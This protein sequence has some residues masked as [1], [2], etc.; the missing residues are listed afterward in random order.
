[1]FALKGSFGFDLIIPMGS[2]TV[3]PFDGHS[4]AARKIYEEFDINVCMLNKLDSIGKIIA[5]ALMYSFRV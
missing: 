3:I 4:L 5:E 1:M 2:L